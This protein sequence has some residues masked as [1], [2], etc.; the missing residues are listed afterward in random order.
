MEQVQ[1]ETQELQQILEAT[2]QQA[3]TD[4]AALQDEVIVKV[5]QSRKL[6]AQIQEKGSEVTSANQRIQELQQNV[7][8]SVCYYKTDGYKPYS[9]SLEP[10]AFG[11]STYL[12]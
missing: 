6:E 12:L 9:S 7:Q 4:I 3:A 8:V 2:Q 10:W 11:R 1:C 5:D